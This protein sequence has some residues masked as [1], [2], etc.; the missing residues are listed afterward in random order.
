M[1]SANRFLLIL[2]GAW[3]LS[4]TAS[5]TPASAQVGVDLPD[6]YTR[7]RISPYVDF[8]RRTEAGRDPFR[9]PLTYQRQ[10]LRDFMILD[11][12]RRNLRE[13]RQIREDFQRDLDER[14]QRIF[15]ELGPQ[16]TGRGLTQDSRR[17]NPFYRPSYNKLTGESN[18]IRPTG[19]GVSFGGG[20]RRR[21]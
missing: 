11:E 18:N 19:H 13:Q 10:I 9:D 1:L 12:Q 2:V 3:I 17:L 7:P 8:L 14:T 4:F 15:E 20:G 21:R 6:F 16:T 5:T